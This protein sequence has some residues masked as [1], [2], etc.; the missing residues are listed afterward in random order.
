LAGSGE[1]DAE[2]RPVP[3]ERA[4][5]VRAQAG[6]QEAF[7]RIFETHAPGVRRL[8][9]YL[10]RDGEAAAEATQ[11]AFVRAHRAITGLGEPDGLR[12]WLLGIAR[13]V[14]LEQL[15]ARKR[16]MRSEGLDDMDDSAAGDR[17]APSPEQLLLGREADELLAAALGGL[18]EDR[19]TA[20]LLRIDH[21]LSYEEIASV[22]GWPLH[23]VKNEVRKAR[24][25]LRAALA[26][27]LRGQP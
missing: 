8:A 24:L 13:N 19:R 15:R 26:A 10:L 7:R 16:W 3:I 23:K 4:L 17:A 22:M 1:P 18:S 21:D 9:R 2:P 27:Y 25:G 11:E 6:D 20:L 5:V 12:P 14:C